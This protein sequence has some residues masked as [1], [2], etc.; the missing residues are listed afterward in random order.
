MLRRLHEWLRPTDTICFVNFRPQ[1]FLD[2]TCAHRLPF[3]QSLLHL[4]PSSADRQRTQ[5]LSQ[6]HVQHVKLWKVIAHL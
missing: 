6:V 2:C 3:T 1:H 5:V 4:S